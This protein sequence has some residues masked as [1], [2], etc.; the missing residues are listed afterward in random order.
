MNAV[1]YR[2]PGPPDVLEYADVPQPVIRDR[3]LLVR[4]HAAGVNPVDWKMRRMRL[5]VPWQ[6]WPMIP[7]SDLAG[8]ILRTGAAVTR[9]RVG[10]AVYGFLSPFTGG[11][12]AEYATVDENRIA[13]KPTTCS[14]IEAAAV[15]IAGLAA[16]QALRDLGHIAAGH[17]VLINGASGGVGMFAVQIAK[18][19]GATVAA[20]TSG[21][22]VAFAKTLGADH[23]VDYQTEDFTR[24]GGPYDI[25]FDAVAGRSFSD[26][27]RVLDRHGVY[28]STLPSAATVIDS[29]IGPVIQGRRARAVMVRAS[30]DDLD[31]LTALIDS[32]NV[33]PRID[34]VFPLA[35]AAEAHALSEAGAV[36]GKLVLRVGE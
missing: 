33:R 21:K 7:G 20:V 31:A 34:R 19:F 1:I 9:F 28:V 5:R 25:V 13:R 14:F 17:R 16:L 11:A 26:C 35:Q 30:A 15:P 32:G 3:Q 22:N 4:V 29:A 36:R 8:E 23:V 27:R 18:S 6:R 2:C 24:V 10:D 12:Y